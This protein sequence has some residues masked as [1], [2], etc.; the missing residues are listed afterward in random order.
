MFVRHM[1]GEAG[2]RLRWLYYRRRLG[3]LGR[4]TRIDEGVHIVNPEQVFIGAN[5]WIAANAFLGAAAPDLT[6]REVVRR[7]N[8]AFTAAEGELRLADYVY[9]A[10]QALINAHG[11]VAIGESVS[12]SAGAKLYSSSHYY[13]GEGG[14]AGVPEFLPGMRRQPGDQCLMLG[15][16]VVHAG[17]QVGSHAIVLP[18]V[19][20]GPRTWVGAGAVVTGSLEPNRVYN[21]LP[22]DRQR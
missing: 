9:I 7:P 21:P 17:S 15:P 2:V 18:G 14:D 19:T 12:I 22:V 4:G 20:V 5:C 13:R 10:P 6:R 16:I 1:P 8:P 3:A 11:G